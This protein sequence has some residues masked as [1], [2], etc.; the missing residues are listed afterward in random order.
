MPNRPRRRSRVT[1]GSRMFKPAVGAGGGRNEPL[2]HRLRSPSGLAVRA[3][4]A[5][6]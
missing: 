4:T 3:E 2:A 5:I 6:F 1:M